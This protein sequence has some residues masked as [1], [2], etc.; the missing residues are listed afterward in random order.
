MMKRKPVKYYFG[1]YRDYAEK[2]KVAQLC[3]SVDNLSCEILA[4]P[5]CVTFEKEYRRQAISLAKTFA[6]NNGCKLLEIN[7]ETYR[8]IK[9]K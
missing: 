6:F 4:H 7:F 3:L 9:I 5:G 2:I 8:T 1:V